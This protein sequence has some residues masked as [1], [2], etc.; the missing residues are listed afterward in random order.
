MPATGMF[1]PAAWTVRPKYKGEQALIAASV[2]VE[3]TPD[4]SG[5]DSSEVLLELGDWF[6]LFRKHR[7]AR[8]TYKRVWTML[9]KDVEARDRAFA[10]PKLLYTPWIGNPDQRRARVSEETGPG[11]I[12]LSLSVNIY[13]KVHSVEVVRSEP[14]IFDIKVSRLTR[15]ARYRPAFVEGAP[16]GTDNVQVI[17]R[18]EYF[19]PM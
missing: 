18:F 9:G 7:E 16:V 10:K 13:G 19:L 12:E 3:Q 11:L 4:P 1:Q 2:L 14:E 5:V 6:L 17:H 15:L 8:E